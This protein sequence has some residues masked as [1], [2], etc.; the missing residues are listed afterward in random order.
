MKSAFLAIASVV[1]ALVLAS[2]PQQPPRRP[3]GQPSLSGAPRRLRLSGRR[4]YDLRFI[5]YDADSGGSQVGSTVTKEDVTVTA[6]LFTTSLDFGAVF[7]GNKRF[8]E[9]GCD[10]GERRSVHG[11]G[12]AAGADAHAECGV[13]PDGA[14]VGRERD[15]GGFRR[16]N[17]RGQRR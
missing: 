14:V 2:A 9:I 12:I 11:G 6:G 4:A 17:R 8:L 7:D 15:A 10:P 13:E 3:S 1:A 5:L 16:R